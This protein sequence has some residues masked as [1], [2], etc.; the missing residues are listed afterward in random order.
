M[1]TPVRSLVLAFSAVWVFGLPVRVGGSETGFTLD[2]FEWTAGARDSVSDLIEATG[3][4]SAL[5]PVQMK[6]EAFIIE[7]LSIFLSAGPTA[8]LPS[9]SIKIAE[10]ALSV[11]WEP[12]NEGYVLEETPQLSDQADWK[13]VSEDI[14]GEYHFSPRQT[15]AFF[16]LRR[17]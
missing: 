17:R 5:Q 8:P 1:L 4:L 3:V 13:P 15:S 10:N 9:L 6:G 12:V 11:S 14:T 7:P 2:W 16:R